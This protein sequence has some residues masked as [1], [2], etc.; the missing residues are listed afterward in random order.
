MNI[1]TN[2]LSLI[3]YNSSDFEDF[4]K[5]I[6]DD[7]VM[8]H[9]SG[10]GN[11]RIVAKEKFEKLLKTNS[12]NDLY[13]FYKVILKESNKMIGF[14]KFTPYEKHYFEIGYALLPSYW[15]KGYTQEMVTNLTKHGLHN[16]SN[17][18]LMAIVKKGHVASINVL[19]KNGYQIY[20]EEDFK[21]SSCLF[22]EYAT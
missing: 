6:C 17:N 1:S 18:K 21:G 9:I 5:V 14:A 15:R 2:R 13:G 20:K 8:L 10:K 16:F 11:T 12:E 3:K 7:E 22:L 4:C 19:E